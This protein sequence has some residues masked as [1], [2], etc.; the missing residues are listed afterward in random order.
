MRTSRWLGRHD[1]EP[2]VHTLL[3]LAFTPVVLD[4][5]GVPVTSLIAGIGVVGVGIGLAL[6]GVLGN[7]M[8][9]LNHFHEA[10]LRWRIHQHCQ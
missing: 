3:V 1:L 6:Q 8:A 7:L 4:K 9:G 2:L 10:V 5:F